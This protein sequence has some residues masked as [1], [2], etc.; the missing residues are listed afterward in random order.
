M[1]FIEN[2]GLL[3]SF[4]KFFLIPNYNVNF[5]VTVLR[6]IPVFFFLYLAF[7]DVYGAFSSREVSSLHEI[8]ELGDMIAR[9]ELLSHRIVF[10]LTFLIAIKENSKHL[11][12]ISN[13]IEFERKLEQV[14]HVKRKPL[15]YLRNNIEISFT[16]MFNFAFY[17]VFW[18]HAFPEITLGL[19]FRLLTHFTVVT[20]NNLVILYMTRIIK[21]ISDLSNYVV[22]CMKSDDISVFQLFVDFLKLPQI[23]NS[24]TG[25]TIFLSFLQHVGSTAMISY[26]IFWL[27]MGNEWIPPKVLFLF[28]CSVWSI[29]NIIYTAHISFMGNRLHQMIYKLIRHHNNLNEGLELTRRSQP[30]IQFN[31]H[32][33]QLWLGHIDKK[34]I[35]AGSLEVT[36]AGFFSVQ[37][38]MTTY[39][40][41]LLQFKQLE[42][43]TMYR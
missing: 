14:C 2:L 9:F 10:I 37:S 20:T 30:P 38:I 3:L 32:Q 28:V 18:G 8:S 42:D 21:E 43:S 5:P 7:K 35:V 19:F 11:Y 1:S 33:I 31:K 15:G 17:G 22:F 36:N 40:I 12:L 34:S 23:V 16:V 29:S 25:G 13:L 24:A 26:F 39:L 27:L 41:I 4:Q 6:S